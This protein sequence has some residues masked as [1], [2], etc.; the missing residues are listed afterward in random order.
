MASKTAVTNDA[1]NRAKITLTVTPTTTGA[2]WTVAV[3]DNNTSYGGYAAS[4][5]SW[6]LTIN[7]R[8]IFNI[9]GKSYD[10]GSGVIANPYFPTSRGP[11]AI[12]LDPGTYSA[13]ATFSGDGSTVGTATATVS[14][15][16]TSSTPTTYAVTINPNNG[17]STYNLGNYASGASVT[18]PAAP[19]RTGYSFDYWVRSDTSEIV[20]P[21]NSFTMPASATTL[22]ASWTSSGGGTTYYSY[23]YNSNGGSITPNGSGS[24][25][26]GTVISLGDPGIKSGFSFGGWYT[27]SGLTVSAGGIGS[28]FAIN[29]NVIFY[30]KWNSSSSGIPAWPSPLPTLAQFI[31]GQPYTD[32]ITASNMGSG[33]YSIYSGSLP[34]GISI[35]SATGALSGTVS[36]ASDYSFTVSATNGSGTITQNYSGTISGILRVRQN[37]AWVKS[38]AKK[39]E[40]EI[41][42]PGTVRVW[43]NGTWLYGS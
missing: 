10:F 2:D 43:S 32:A 6:S 23:S 28:S 8:S 39:R 20:Y 22:A 30:A 31:A 19:T 11:T 1:Q 14:F 25:Q 33:T 4:A 13:S 15:T 41:W 40:G 17:S 29:S 36:T 5:G 42:K 18:A 34:G 9:P 26:S 37:E 38:I 7:G 27:N 12:A 21:G 3:A 16:V 24:I 35:N